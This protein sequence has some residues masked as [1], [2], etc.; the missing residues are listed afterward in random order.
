[1]SKLNILSF[2]IGLQS[3]TNII[4]EAIIFKVNIEDNIFEAVD[5]TI[6]ALHTNDDS[7]D[8]GDK[9]Q[10]FDTTFH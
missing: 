7:D 3:F 9:N 10:N 6:K 2:K 1:M 8:D 4:H 5:P